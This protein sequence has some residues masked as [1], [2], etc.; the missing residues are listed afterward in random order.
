MS[1][2]LNKRQ[3]FDVPDSLTERE[4]GKSSYCNVE[5]RFADHPVL[6]PEKSR[7][8]RHNVYDLGIVLHTRVKRG[9]GDVKAQPN[10]SGLTLRFDKGDRQSKENFEAAKQAVQRCR[11]AWDH[12][13]LFRKAPVTEMEVRALAQLKTV[14]E[15]HKGVLVDI[16]GKLVRK[17]FDIDK[18][19]DDGD[20]PDLDIEEAPPAAPQPEPA[21]AATPAPAR[22]T[23]RSRKARTTA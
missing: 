9:P 17:D 15:P 19:E 20:E 6:N 14:P 16:G 4:D 11:A 18:D 22:K 8:A 23:S 5:A 10:M 7:I 3:W 21:A 2:P 12:Y 13:Q 1:K